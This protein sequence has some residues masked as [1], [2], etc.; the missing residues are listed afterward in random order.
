MIYQHKHIKYK[1][2][3]KWFINTIILKFT[4]TSKRI[5]YHLQF[6]IDFGFSVELFL[7][8]INIDL[9]EPTVILYFI[10][11]IQ[12]WHD[13]IC[14]LT[15][16]QIWSQEMPVHRDN[17]CYFLNWTNNKL[18]FHLEVVKLVEF[19]LSAV[20]S[21]HLS[22]SIVM[23]RGIEYH[24]Q[25]HLLKVDLV[26]ATTS[27]IPQLVLLLIS[28]PARL[29]KVLLPSLVSITIFTR[30]N[31]L[32]TT[33]NS[34]IPVETTFCWSVE[35][36]PRSAASLSSLSRAAGYSLECVRALSFFNCLLLSLV[37]WPQ[38][39]RVVISGKQRKVFIW[40]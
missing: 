22:P 38:Q 12:Y 30:G 6:F 18:F 31:N 23:S 27:D 21:G 3:G 28:E 4:N 5:K 40:Y 11:L 20:L 7:P 36:R 13:D 35:D 1:E 39:Q 29:Q 26:L 19:S 34:S 32:Q 25:R 17:F 33:W 8:S 24:L 15:F 10:K 16:N 2:K 14:W 37:L 9:V